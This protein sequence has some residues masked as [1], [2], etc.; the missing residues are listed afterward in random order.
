MRQVCENV[1]RMLIKEVFV[2]VEALTGKPFD[3]D[4]CCDDEGA[5]SHCAS[6]CS[7]SSSFLK[8]DVSGQ[9]VWM[10]VPTNRIELFIKHYLKCKARAPQTT[11]ACVVVPCWQGPWRRLLTGMSCSSTKSRVLLCLLRLGKGATVR[12]MGQLLGLLRSG[13][14]LQLL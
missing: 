7:P 11:S 9:H 1:N 13:M 4:A 5:N 14:M 6:Y 3:I 10:N 8:G 12:L 2:E